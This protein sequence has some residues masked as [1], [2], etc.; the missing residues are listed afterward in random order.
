M[1]PLLI[2]NAGVV[3]RGARGFV[4]VGQLRA[5]SFVPAKL[6]IPRL[7]DNDWLLLRDRVKLEGRR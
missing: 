7:P 5:E 1:H 2:L 3:G 4:L 6:H